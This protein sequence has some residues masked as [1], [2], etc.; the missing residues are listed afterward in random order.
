MIKYRLR[1]SLP[2]L[3]VN[4]RRVHFRARAA[5]RSDSDYSSLSLDRVSTTV[6]ACPGLGRKS[7][8]S[9]A[10]RNSALDSSV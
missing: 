3:S 5:L 9:A 10:A 2:L 7:R 8:A 4:D 6:T 1:N